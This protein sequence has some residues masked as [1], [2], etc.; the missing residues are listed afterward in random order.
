M[1]LIRKW[2]YSMGTK[3]PF[4]EWPE[5]AH[6]FL[7]RHGLTAG[8]FLYC[9]TD[10]I[11]GFSELSPHS[12]QVRIASSG[13]R[14]AQKACPAFGEPR[15]FPGKRFGVTDELILS[16]IDTGGGCTK[17][18]L[19]PLMK[20]IHK[21][22]GFSTSA[23][24][25]Y[26]VDFFGRVIPWQRDSR[27]GRNFAA[28]Q[29]LPYDGLLFLDEQ[30]V[31]SGIK[32]ERYSFGKQV[33]TF[34][35][36]LLHDGVVMDPTPYMETMRELLPN[37]R[38]QDHLTILFSETEQQEYAARQA[39]AEPLAETCRQW[40]AARLP[41]GDR[42]APQVLFPEYKMAPQLKA[43]A[44]RYGFAYKF[45]VSGNFTLTRRTPRGHCLRLTVDSGPSHYEACFWLVFQGL[46]FV[47]RLQELRFH[48]NDQ[49][50]FDACAERVVA[51]AAEFAR[52]A[53]SPLAEFYP[54]TP[55]WY[56]P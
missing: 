35:V 45:V 32:L 41:Q 56:Q 26:D 29:N 48:L 24:Y 1:R 11:S 8:A 53:L 28:Q 50:E 38:P 3:P 12:Q 10:V 49:A 54:D 22:W 51:T 27:N 30:P 44:K 20:R 19:L 47:H 36:D 55:D 43:L 52:D 16:N 39:A 5:L 25:Y 15:L 7:G 6:Q 42:Q 17:A 4:S 18:E 33:I 23:I 21:S 13:C 34:S 46:G 37:R 9:F 31:G 14:R 40:L 2:Y